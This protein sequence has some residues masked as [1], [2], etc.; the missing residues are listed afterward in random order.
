MSNQLDIVLERLQTKY[1]EEILL[2]WRDNLLQNLADKKANGEP[3]IGVIRKGINNLVYGRDLNGKT[4]DNIELSDKAKNIADASVDDVD[5]AL[6]ESI[7][8]TRLQDEG[9]YTNKD[10]DDLEEEKKTFTK[11]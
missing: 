11:I 4:L 10:K 1:P 7:R 2:N 5:A 3:L 9:G 6:A 8:I